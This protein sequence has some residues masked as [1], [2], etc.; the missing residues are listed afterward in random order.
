[1]DQLVLAVGQTGAAVLPNE[2][3]HELSCARF[4]R[5]YAALLPEIVVREAM[6]A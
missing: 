2:G 6:P 3:H 4:L 5:Q 1:M